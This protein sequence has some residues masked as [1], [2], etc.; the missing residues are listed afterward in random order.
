MTEKPEFVTRM[1]FETRN[2]KAHGRLYGIVDD[3][4]DMVMPFIIPSIPVKPVV[5][6]AWKFKWFWFLA[7][8]C[9]V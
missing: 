1:S 4:R 9:L 8:A 2:E 6:Q 5:A 3:P 7:L